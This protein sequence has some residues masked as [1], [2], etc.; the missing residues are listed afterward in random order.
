M[1][2]SSFDNHITRIVL[3]FAG[4]SD[5]IALLTWRLEMRRWFFLTF[6]SLLTAL[7]G[8]NKEG[9]ITTGS[10]GPTITGM[11]PST[12]ARGQTNLDGRIL[13]T[14]Y[15]GIVAVDLGAGIEIK[16]TNLL[17]PTEIAITFDVLDSA[18]PGARTIRVATIAGVATNDTFFTISD[19]RPPV[20]SFNVTPAK[21]SKETVF[22]FDASASNDQGGS[23]TSFEWDFG[24]GTKGNGRTISH[25]F[26][27]A[28]TFKTLLTVTDNQQGK[29]TAQKDIEVNNTRPPI[30]RFSVEPHLGDPDT[31][32]RFDA[33]NSADDGR[34]VNYAWNF[35]DGHHDQGKVV[36]HVFG[37]ASKF[38]VELVVTDNDGL[39]ASTFKDVEISGKPPIASFI[40]TPAGGPPGTVFHFD[41]SPSSDSDGEVVQFAWNMGDGTSLNGK[42]VS[43]SYSQ[44][45]TFPV[46]LNVTDDSG[47]KDITR[48]NLHVDN[49]P[50]PPPPP[51]TGGTQCTNPVKS[52]GADRYGT[53]ISDDQANR[54]FVLQLYNSA[55]CSTA[56]YKCGDVKRFIPGGE[57]WFGEICAMWD[58]GNNTF[59]IKVAGGKA[60]P[61][62]GMKDVYLH[63]QSCSQFSVCP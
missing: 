29:A 32:F 5:K 35:G 43:H 28:G 7:V 26:A 36:R 54:T 21:G 4:F 38:E 51:P 10:G 46:E 42:Q 53:V 27:S 22:A 50:P 37:T 56:Y 19:N 14:G 52:K 20:A 44:Q 34:I 13:G 31:N 55:S 3:N 25:K 33:S 17:S 16:S 57:D 58:L 8:C 59:R 48:N 63:F 15:S 18:A 62:A 9:D 61:T 11:T 6:L 60:W 39:Q 40:V 2:V 24:D 1:K 30:P 23:I 12:V 45:G 47:L 41:G 49:N